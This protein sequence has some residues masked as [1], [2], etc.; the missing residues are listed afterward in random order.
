VTRLLCINSDAGTIPAGGCVRLSEVNASA[1][2]K[3]EIQYTTV[4]PDG[5][6]LFYY[7]NG[8]VPT[9][10][11]KTFYVESPA[12]ITRA[13]VDM[14]GVSFGDTVG[15]VSGSWTMDDTG[16]GFSVIGDEGADGLTPVVRQGA[17]AGGGGGHHIGFEITEADCTAG[18]V[19]TVVGSIGRYTGCDIPPGADDYGDY[20]IYDYYG[21]LT[22]LE[23]ADMVGQKALAIYWHPYPG[24]TPRW[25]LLMVDYG[26]D[27]P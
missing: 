21:F 19:T 2:S 9:A 27:C 11:T 3:G 14:T 12:K 24:C 15:P 16:T 25:D 6:D 26:G 4:K 23:D 1:S 10:T 22:N 8:P 18:T 7:F 17:G 20:L 5:E 13:L